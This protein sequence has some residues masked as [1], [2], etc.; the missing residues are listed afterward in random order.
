MVKKVLIVDD[1]AFTRNLLKSMLME[2]GVDEV[3]EAADGREAV[4]KYGQTSPRLVFMDIMMP[5]V[6]GL[7]ALKQIIA[8]DKEANVVIYTSAQQESLIK[9]AMDYGASDF[10]AKPLAKNDVFALVKKYLH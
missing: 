5:N 10:I 6:N 9:Q 1:S 7:E 8:A 3:I 4:E 2:S